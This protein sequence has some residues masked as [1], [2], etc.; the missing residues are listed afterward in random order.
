MSS[1][2]DLLEC[3]CSMQQQV[4][5]TDTVA[6]KVTVES[7]TWMDGLIMFGIAVTTRVQIPTEKL[8]LVSCQGK[9]RSAQISGRFGESPTQ[10]DQSDLS[11]ACC[12]GSR[13]FDT[14]FGPIVRSSRCG[15]VRR[16]ENDDRQRSDSVKLFS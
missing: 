3:L 14:H 16:R 6:S 8:Q 9:R 12:G 13:P 10:F 15:V 7:G 5:V 1:F 11:G 2:I 4:T